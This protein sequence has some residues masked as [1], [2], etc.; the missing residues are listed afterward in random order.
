MEK[1]FTECQN[2]TQVG[3][4]HPNFVEKTFAGGS[5]TVKFVKVFRSFS[6]VL[7]VLTI[8]L[9]LVGHNAMEWYVYIV[10]RST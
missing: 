1:T 7:Y 10:C 6:E 5:K 2:L 3:T 8:L 4:A 9:R